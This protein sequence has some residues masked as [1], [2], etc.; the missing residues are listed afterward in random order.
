MALIAVAETAQDVAS[1]LNQFLDPVADYSADITAL[2]AH[3]FSTSS[4][5]RILDTTIG[6]VPIHRRYHYIANDLSIVTDSLQYTFTDVKRIFG[7]LGRAVGAPP[8]TYRRVWRDLN[9]HF[10][11][12]S[13][14][15]LSRRLDFCQIFV[16]GLT[17]TLNEGYGVP[18]M[19]FASRWPELTSCQA[20]SRR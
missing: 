2:I 12:E 19:V 14:N 4:A 9:D 13:G 3:C 16:E 18:N 10:H 8:A 17:C 7:R 5:L 1:G 6:E 11:E 20:T 15:T